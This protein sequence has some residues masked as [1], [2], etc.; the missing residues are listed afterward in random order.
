MSHFGH[1]GWRQEGCR[2]CGFARWEVGPCRSWVGVIR[3]GA[4]S[5][6]MTDLPPGCRSMFVTPLVRLQWALVW[7]AWAGA[8][9]AAIAA[10]RE[11]GATRG[12]TVAYATSYEKSP[13]NSFVGY[14]GIVF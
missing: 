13:G 3:L 2:S 7:L 11:M 8:A 14:V 10:G 12:E 1:L 9:A 4:M 5:T 6:R